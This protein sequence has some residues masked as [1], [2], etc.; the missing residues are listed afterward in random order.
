MFDSLWCSGPKGPS[1]DILLKTIFLAIL[2]LTS[3]YI[4]PLCFVFD[5][6]IVNGGFI[7][8]VHLGENF[9]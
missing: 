3:W 2:C 1:Q 5:I 4:L 7:F 9:T 6:E 8:Q